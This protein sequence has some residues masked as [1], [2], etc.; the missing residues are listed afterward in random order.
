MNIG[1]ST[2]LDNHK[3]GIIPVFFIGY[4]S[5]F[6]VENCV[7]WDS[8]YYKHLKNC[9]KY[10]E[11]NSNSVFL[12]KNSVFP[13]KIDVGENIYTRDPNLVA[14]ERIDEMGTMLIPTKDSDCIGNGNSLENIKLMDNAVRIIIP[15]IK[16][17]AFLLIFIFVDFRATNLGKILNFVKKGI[18]FNMLKI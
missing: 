13:S 15:P 18:F 7:I 14:L 4:D 5:K 6:L 9:Y 17:L 12:I 2:F 10:F 8:K 11:I 3:N 16:I 1:N